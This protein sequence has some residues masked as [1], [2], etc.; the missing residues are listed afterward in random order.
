MS[1]VKVNR[2]IRSL[3]SMVYP[4]QCL[5]H[6]GKEQMLLCLGYKHLAK[7]EYL[8]CSNSYMKYK[9]LINFELNSVNMIWHIQNLYTL[10]L[11]QFFNITIDSDINGTSIT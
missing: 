10:I 6:T 8:V 9:C 5:L 2:R 11:A 4:L 3:R 1:S 7:G